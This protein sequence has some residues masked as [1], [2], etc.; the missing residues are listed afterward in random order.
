MVNTK[1]GPGRG[2]A[3]RQ[4]AAIPSKP[5]KSATPAA[6]ATAAK[7]A[8]LVLPPDPEPA[9]SWTGRLQIQASPDM[10]D[11]LNRRGARPDRGRSP[12]SLTNVM[13]QQ[14]ELFMASIDESDPRLSRGFPQEYYDLTIEL[15][16]QP[17]TLNAD[18]IR[19]LDHYLGRQPHLNY[20]LEQIG[21]D[22]K[23]Y[24][25]AIA[26]LN[27]SERLHLVEQAHVRHAPPPPE[28]DSPD[29]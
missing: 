1:P 7:P 13:R 4:A 26:K 9:T 22:R 15:V 2:G 27:F 25:A 12:F 18:A 23:A 28:P 19:L 16:T 24:L 17:W 3:R 11:F 14:F 20:L 21:A 6:P 29:L 10:V 5:A 8:K